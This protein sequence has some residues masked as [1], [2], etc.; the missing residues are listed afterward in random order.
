MLKP[1]RL[2][3]RD[4]VRREKEIIDRMARGSSA[5]VTTVGGALRDDRARMSV[6]RPSYMT[7]YTIVGGEA[8]TTLYL[9]WGYG[10]FGTT[11]RFEP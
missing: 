2:K 4:R 9:G 3:Q 11:F 7:T 10:A 6:S 8:Q 1:D 5:G